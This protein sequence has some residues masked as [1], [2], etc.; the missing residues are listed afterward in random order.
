VRSAPR[1]RAPEILRLTSESASTANSTARVFLCLISSMLPPGETVAL[2][3]ARPRK[4]DGATQ[5]GAQANWAASDQLR[6]GSRT[7][8]WS[9]IGEHPAFTNDRSTANTFQTLRVTAARWGDTT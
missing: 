3:K 7:Q 2:G 5:D 8:H 1:R 4:I 9:V 6:M